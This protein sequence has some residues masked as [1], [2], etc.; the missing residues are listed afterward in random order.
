MTFRTHHTLHLA[1]SAALAARRVDILR[2]LFIG[3]GA[4]TF[5][6]A[7]APR[8]SRE[9]ADVLSLL[10]PTQRTAVLRNLPEVARTRLAEAGMTFFD[11]PVCTRKK[12]TFSAARDWFLRKSSMA[13]RVIGPSN[14]HSSSRMP[15]PWATHPLTLTNSENTGV[16]A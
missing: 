6:L 5:A 15:T 1:M 7:I 9:A 3:H 8:P 14:Q 13:D 16:S 12:S 10:A 4:S 2:H 11:P